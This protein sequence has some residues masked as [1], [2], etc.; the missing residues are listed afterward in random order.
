MRTVEV[1][2]PQF[3]RLKRKRGRAVARR[4]R[5]R[6]VRG[7]VP[8]AQR[9]FLRTGG[10][11][12]RYAGAGGEQKFFDTDVND[13]VIS[14]TMTINNLTIIPQGTTE[15][16][17]I[18]RKIRISK[19]LW[20]YNVLLSA[21]TAAASTSDIL[22]M[23]LV[24]DTQTN[25]AAFVAADLIDTDVMDS[26]NNLANSSRFKVLWSRTVPMVCGGGAAPSGAALVFAEGRDWV[27]GSKKCN[28]II[29][30]DNTATDGTIGT[31]RSNNL[32]WCTQS[33]D[34]ACVGVGTLRLR[35]SD[36]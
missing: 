16:T 34:A 14:A 25:G 15:S 4:T 30:Y 27:I 18:G 9:G 3:R 23:F 22:K 2:M 6:M 35:F 33:T 1:D 29:E 26:F 7:Q 36:A 11:Y 13:A 24:Q 32:Y 10:F 20:K 19:V 8:Y 12:G 5:R 17:R 31:V 21:A 28:I